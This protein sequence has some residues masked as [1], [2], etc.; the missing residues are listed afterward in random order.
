M[1]VFTCVMHTHNIKK[2]ALL[3]IICNFIFKF[4]TNKKK[5]Q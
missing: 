5:L 2:H 3:D 4:L 1:H